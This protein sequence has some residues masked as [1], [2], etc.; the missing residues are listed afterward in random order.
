MVELCPF[1][2]LVAFLYVPTMV[3]RISSLVSIVN[4]TVPSSLRG[5]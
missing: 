1:S 2:F 3:R 5:Q 4:L